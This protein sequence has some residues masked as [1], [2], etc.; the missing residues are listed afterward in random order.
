MIN[1]TVQGLYEGDNISRISMDKS[2]GETEVSWFGEQGINNPSSKHNST[3]AI[4]H[5]EE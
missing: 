5:V 4:K 3:K 2:G 1:L